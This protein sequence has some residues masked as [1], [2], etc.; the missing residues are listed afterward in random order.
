MSFWT[1]VKSS[2][3]LIISK[4]YHLVMLSIY[5]DQL[6]PTL[7]YSPKITALFTLGVNSEL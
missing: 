5:M 4:N 6:E 7:T 1:H 3:V 2:R